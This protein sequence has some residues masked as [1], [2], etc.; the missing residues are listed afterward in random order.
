MTSSLSQQ[1]NFDANH[2]V[3]SFIFVLSERT[4]IPGRPCYHYHLFQAWTN[5]QCP[6]MIQVSAKL[7]FSFM[8]NMIMDQ[9]KHQHLGH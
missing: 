7:I 2:K 9:L 8:F 3:C 5:H 6:D 4:H 1:R